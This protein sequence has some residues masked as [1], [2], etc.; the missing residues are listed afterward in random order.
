MS[1][2]DVFWIGFSR[3]GHKLRM[4]VEIKMLLTWRYRIREE[5]KSLSNQRRVK[6]VRLACSKGDHRDLRSVESS[7]MDLYQC[8]TVH[9]PALC[10]K[11]Q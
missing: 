8:A 4:S 10:H 3:T 6:T 2:V 11:N 1:G 9:R 7:V 5:L